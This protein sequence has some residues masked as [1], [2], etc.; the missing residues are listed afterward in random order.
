MQISTQGLTL[1]AEREGSR[2]EAY[3]DT[4]G[5]VTIGV[6]HVSPSVKLG[7]VWTDEQVRDAL[8]ADLKWCEDAINSH[9]KVPLVGYQFDALVSFVFNVGAAAFAG[10]HLLKLINQDAMAEAATAFDAWHIPPEIIPRRTGEREQFK[11]A[12]FDARIG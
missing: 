2:N 8:A 7:D 6:G 10:S 9:V 3:E 1:L 4:K 5:I 12:S 11:G